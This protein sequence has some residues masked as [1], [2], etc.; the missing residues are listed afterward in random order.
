MYAEK[1]ALLSVLHVSHSHSRWWVNYD[2]AMRVHVFAWM[3][4]YVQVHVHMCMEA[5][6]QPQASSGM[7]PTSF[8][9]SHWSGAQR[10][11]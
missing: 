1:G 6:E 3:H 8:K 4:L 10:L 5:R 7:L 9:V 2:A 11:S